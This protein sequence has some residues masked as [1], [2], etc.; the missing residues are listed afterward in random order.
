M[1]GFMPATATI[2]IAVVNDR[3]PP[4][5]LHALLVLLGFIPDDVVAAGLD[6]EQRAAGAVGF[7]NEHLVVDDNRIRGI[8]ALKIFGPPGKVE[9]NFA[10]LRLKSDQSAACEDE[11]P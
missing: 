4:V 5:A 11:S 9:L 1:G 8:D 2:Q 6:L 10:G 3:R 7:G